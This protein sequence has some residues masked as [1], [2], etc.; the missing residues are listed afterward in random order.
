M[1]VPSRATS[2]AAI[3]AALIGIAGTPAAAQ[4]RFQAA[5]PVRGFLSANGIFQTTESTFGERFEF[6]EFVETGSIETRFETKASVGLDGAAGV[7]LWRNLGIGVGITTY[8]PDAQSGGGAV[9]ARIPHPLYHQQHREVIGEAGLRRKETAIHGS[10]LYFI[11]VRAN[12]LAIVGGGPTFF[13]A[14]Q[15]FVNDVRYDHEYPYDTATFRGVERDNESASGVGFNASLDVA[16]RFSRAFGLGG[17]VRYSQATLPFTPA[18]RSVN[19][20]VGGLQA[21]VGLRVLF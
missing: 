9:T 6:E 21:G 1:R 18:E 13:Q 16:W 4:T 20:D 8:A 7:R 2:A 19:V 11:P 14:E 15:S 10:L 17:V 12:V 3:A 5:P